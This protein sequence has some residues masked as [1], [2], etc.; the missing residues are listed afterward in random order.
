MNKRNIWGMKSVRIV[1]LLLGD[2]VVINLASFF[3]IILRYGLAFSQ[4]PESVIESYKLT[5]PLFTI[6]SLMFIAAFKLYRSVWEYASV[7]EILYVILACFCSTLA[8]FAAGHL[9]KHAMPRGVYVIEF[10]LLTT[11]ILILRFGYRMAR[12]I[13][14]ELKA[15]TFQKR[16]RVMIIGAGDAAS[17]LITEYN[18]AKAKGGAKVVCLI[19]DN[20][21]KIGNYLRGVKVVG[22]R[23]SITKFAKKF[24][25]DEIIYAIPSSSA[26][27]RAEILNICKET[28][29]SLKAIPGL[30]QII[31][32]KVKLSDMRDVKIEDLLGRDPVK[33]QTEEV[34]DY[35]KGQ[36][37]IVTGGG[38]SIGSE[39]CRQIAMH[40]P[41]Q[42]IIFD[43]YENNAY[44]IQN[45]LRRKYGGGL[46]LVTLIGSVRDSKRINQVFEKYRPNIVFHAAAHKHVPLMEDSPNEAVK[47]NVF[48]TLKVSSAAIKYGA[49]RF[50]LISTDK[51]VNPTNIMGATKRMCEMVVQSA[52]RQGKTEFVAVRFGNVL[53]SNGS[54]IPLF[55]KQ[56]AAGGP[57][58]VTDPRII[59]YFMTIPEAVSLVLQAG[60][61][62]KGGEIFVLDMGEPV[63][64]LDLAENL[65]RLSG[66]TPYVDIDIKFTGLRPGEKLY[67]E[68]L[69]E[70]EGLQ[71]TENSLIHIGKPIKFNE[72]KFKKDLEALY[73]SMMDDHIDIRSMVQEIVPTY[74]PGSDLEEERQTD[75][76]PIDVKQEIEPA[77]C[78]VV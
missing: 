24:N 65:I 40:A 16:K 15:N 6:L 23:E 7:N 48:G 46:N 32:G 58:T 21:N 36:V 11:G 10:L 50:I 76:T 59:R 37:V 42:L 49:K 39:L 64:I 69:M 38:G 60:A 63:K 35:V 53:G 68:L 28:G 8:D 72:E 22:N 2:I 66:H 33:M 4:T 18:L 45:E 51:A 70:E 44:D 14:G 75:V 30:S 27:T 73:A 47:N 31:R 41:K 78:A 77:G 5:T 20:P 56:I 19:D 54:V 3:S 26:Q 12:I 74:H 55:K 57:V 29:C 62:A 61:Q 67:E 71:D 17:M 1:A 34:M 43:I 52:N 25:V 13:R 9:L